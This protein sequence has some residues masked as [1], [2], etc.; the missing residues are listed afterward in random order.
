[1]MEHELDKWNERIS[2]DQQADFGPLVKLIT[3]LSPDQVNKH[4]SRILPL[5]LR[6]L[7]HHYIPNKLLGVTAISHLV[8][9]LP[10]SVLRNTGSDQL[11]MHSLKSCLVHEDMVLPVLPILIQSMRRSGIDPLSETCDD[12]VLMILKGLDLS[13]SLSSKQIY[14]KSLF[15]IIDFVGLSIVRLS[16]RIIKRMNDH[17]SYPL[18]PESNQMFHELLTAVH[19]FV[20]VAQSRVHRFSPDILFAVFSFCY[21]NY[22]A[23]Q[24]NPAIRSDVVTLLQAIGVMDSASVQHAIDVIRRNDPEDRMS[25]IL[26]DAQ[27][28]AGEIHCQDTECTLLP[29]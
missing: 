25:L 3:S 10:V 21:S 18:T 5:S 14:W 28:P 11:L 12:V 8:Q 24:S 22:K 20:V 1:M 19:S 7:D 27:L 9:S 15:L 26:Q 2:S 16:K 6:L 23:V 4:F 17:L 29:S 13:S